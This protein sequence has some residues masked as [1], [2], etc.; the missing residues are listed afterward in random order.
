MKQIFF[1]FYAFI[2]ILL[3][4]CSNNDSVEYLDNKLIEG[5][6]SSVFK[7]EDNSFTIDSTVYKFMDN[8]AIFEFYARVMGLENLKL[9]EQRDLGVYSI[10]DKAIFFSVGN[11]KNC[12]YHLSKSDK[13]SL[14]MGS[15]I[16]N[17]PYWTGFKKIKD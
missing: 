17:E 8:K 4:S 1:V 6:W 10:T 5:S 13:D 16:D 7:A 9:E 15:P 14:Y 3:C 11:D 2:A 12:L